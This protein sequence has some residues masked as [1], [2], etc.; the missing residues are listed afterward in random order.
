VVSRFR[1]RLVSFNST[2]AARTLDDRDWLRA[3]FAVSALEPSTKPS[4]QGGRA[5]Q[6]SGRAGSSIGP[7]KV[8]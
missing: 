5:C 1:S 3:G 6:S 7:K 8:S 2:G 4:F